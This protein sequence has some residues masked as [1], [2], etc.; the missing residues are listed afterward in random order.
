V[1]KFLVITERN[2]YQHNVISKYAES[3]DLNL[4]A[5]RFSPSSSVNTNKSTRKASI[6]T[7][8]TTIPVKRKMQDDLR[9]NIPKRRS[10]RLKLKERMQ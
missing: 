8:H 3:P 5:G 4:Q 6:K 10:M 7:L 1:N 2:I 9:A